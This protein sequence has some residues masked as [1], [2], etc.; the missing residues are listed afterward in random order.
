MP[1]DISK[2]EAVTLVKPDKV[3]YLAQT[4]ELVAAIAGR[5]VH[6]IT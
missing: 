2:G 3:Q 1:F 6:K 4:R 5:K